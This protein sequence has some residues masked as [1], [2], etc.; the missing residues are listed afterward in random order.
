MKVD[1]RRDLLLRALEGKGAVLML[2]GKFDAAA[3]LYHQLANKG[4]DN[5]LIVARAER[6]IADVYL[7]Q[8][9]YDEALKILEGKK[10]NIIGDSESGAIE[11]ALIHISKGGVY[12]YKGELR[13]AT[14]E[15]NNGLKILSFIHKETKLKKRFIIKKAQATAFNNLASISLLKGNYKK[16]IKLYNK[17]LKIIKDL[18]EKQAIGTTN[19]NLGLI[20]LDKGEYSKAINLFMNH[21]KISKMIGDK[22]GLSLAIG[23]L[24]LVYENMGNYNKAIGL[25]TRYLKIAQELGDERGIGTACGNLGLAYRDKQQYSEA[26]KFL[27][28]DLVISEK[29]GDRYGSG[30]S[31]LNLAFAY[32]EKDS[33]NDAKKYLFRSF[34]IFK[35]MGDTFDMIYV[36]L[37]LALLGLL[38]IKMG[39][40]SRLSIGKTL[41]FIKN[42]LKTAKE[43]NSKTAIADCYFIFAK[44]YV[45]ISNFKNAQ[46][47]FKKAIKYFN[48]LKSKRMLADS[49]F[50]YAKM[51]KNWESPRLEG[52]RKFEQNLKRA[53]KI[54]N[55]LSL[56]QKIKEVKKVMEQN[57]AND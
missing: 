30:I 2:I 37:G 45:A 38:K 4:Q 32:L 54:Y 1:A 31:C 21:I 20:F 12:R 53:L 16:A 25:F 3:S 26:I 27:L 10:E 15:I 52:T 48:N 35:N 6:S 13:K 11:K 55:E 17:S 43:M 46:I 47:Y 57:F 40:A 49:Y 24:G 19:G 36:N 28:K 9:K 22:R 33:F 44:A 18:N 41:K 34:K 5:P 51:L 23:N 8:G 39:T 42:A 14:K 7:K 56:P 29:I 50:E